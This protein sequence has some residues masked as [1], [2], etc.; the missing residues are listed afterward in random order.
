MYS[1]PRRLAI[2]ISVSELS[3]GRCADQ[4][5]CCWDALRP[6]SGAVRQSSAGV[7][8]VRSEADIAHFE[9]HDSWKEQNGELASGLAVVILPE[10]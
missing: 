4:N 9:Y 6:V 3:L 1:F 5:V 7:L 8:V 2:D 10:C